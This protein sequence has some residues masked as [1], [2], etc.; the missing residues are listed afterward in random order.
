M[1]LNRHGYGC[2]RYRWQARTVAHPSSAAKLGCRKL[3]RQ[4]RHIIVETL[5]LATGSRSLLRFVLCSCILLLRSLD[6]VIMAASATA[7]AGGTGAAG[8]ELPPPAAAVP[9]PAPTADAAPPPTAEPARCMAA[10]SPSAF[11]DDPP[12]LVA[13]AAAAAAA[14]TAVWE[15]TLLTAVL[16]E[17]A[18]RQPT[19]VCR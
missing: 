15:P 7:A 3:H 8:A 11:D 19:K 9:P 6:A 4:R 16:V 1:L 18:A 13:A 5:Q 10:P 12:A 14:P 17:W 2:R